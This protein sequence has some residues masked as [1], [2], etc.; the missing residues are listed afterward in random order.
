MLMLFACGIMMILQ[1]M[2]GLYVMCVC[3]ECGRSSEP[4]HQGVLTVLVLEL[5]WVWV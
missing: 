5:V 2:C 4:S 3:P 1:T